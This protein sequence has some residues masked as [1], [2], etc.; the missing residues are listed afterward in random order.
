VLNPLVCCT[1]QDPLACVLFLDWFAVQFNLKVHFNGV[2]YFLHIL[3]I[4]VNFLRYRLT[5]ILFKIFE[6]IFEIR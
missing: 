4:I 6:I 1:D 3:I 5:I 2:I